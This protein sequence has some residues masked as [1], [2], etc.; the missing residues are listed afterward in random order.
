MRPNDFAKW[1]VMTMPM[2][3]L[4]LTVQYGV[5]AAEDVTLTHVHGL[6]YS[7]D[8]KRLFIP[9]HDG[10]AI[11]NGGR[12]SKAPGPQHDYMGFVG[13]KDCFYSSGHPAQ[14]SGL[15]NPFGL[16]KSSDGGNTW[17]KLGL[18]GESDF[19]IL[20]AGYETNAIYVYNPKPSSRMA[21]AGLY[22]T[23]NDGF[24]WQ[25]AKG[26]GLKGEI[27]SLAVHPTDAAIIAI[28]T[29]SGLFFSQDQGNKLKP[30]ETGH[31]VLAVYFDLDGQHLW[32]GWFDGSPHFA[33]LKLG[34]SKPTLIDLPPLSRDAVSYI[35]QNPVKRGE[36]A[37]ATFQRNI[38]LSEDRGK[39]W[40]QIAD[41]GRTQ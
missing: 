39:S 5:F 38:Y 10:L 30:L 29:D 40:R 34:D 11:Y 7:K 8:G 1:L 36:F 19:H 23:L 22:R 4:C 13:T 9:S 35:A 27:F 31:Q 6:S 3:A 37:I 28:G 21:T 17:Q 32:Y 26:A 41:R 18:E 33:R 12:W 20:A 24:V 2:A 15:V 14:G 25:Q 16:M